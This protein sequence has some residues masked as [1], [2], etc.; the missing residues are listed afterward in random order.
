MET[1]RRDVRAFF[2]PRWATARQNVHDA[3]RLCQGDR[4][5]ATQRRSSHDR[6]R[7]PKPDIQVVEYLPVGVERPGPLDQLEE[8]GLAAVAPDQVKLLPM[9]A[10]SWDR[11]RPDRRKIACVGCQDSSPY[12]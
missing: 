11:H 7:R 6:S 5:V 8:D 9:A 1:L 12:R 4:Q 2:I 10:A 3:L